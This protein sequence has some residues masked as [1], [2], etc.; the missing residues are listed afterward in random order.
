[1]KEAL[2]PDDH[3]VLGQGEL[4]SSELL[5]SSLHL[6]HHRRRRPAPDNGLNAISRR[7]PQTSDDSSTTTDASP[8]STPTTNPTSS[9][10]STPDSTQT[11]SPASTP[12]LA[13]SPSSTCAP[14]DTSNKCEKPTSGNTT[15]LPIVLGAVIPIV[16]AIVLFYFLHR[17]HVRKLRKEDANDRHKSLDFGLEVANGPSKKG[18]KG[19]G[20]AA[21][22]VT[23]LEKELRRDHGL[24]MDMGSPYIL[25]PG[26]HG[27]RES[28]HS[29]S[30]TIKET[31]DR[32][33]P[34]ATFHANDAASMRSLPA[35]QR[36]IHDGSSVY[37][38]RTD[39]SGP[40]NRADSIN[41][42]LLPNASSMPR[43]TPPQESPPS[44]LQTDHTA[45]AE[46][47]PKSVGRKPLPSNLKGVGL[48]I[49]E[50]STTENARDSYFDHNLG[51]I[52]RSNNYLGAFINARDSTL[53]PP[54]NVP[55][56]STSKLDSPALEEEEDALDTLS[57]A[58][59][60]FVGTKQTPSHVARPSV[61][62]VSIEHDSQQKHGSLAVFT[63][64]IPDP[65]EQE[66]FPT[67]TEVRESVIS[68][69]EKDNVR[70]ANLP[71]PSYEMN[72]LS[73]NFRPLPPVEPTDD[74]E[75]RAN[76]IRSFYKE[77]FDDSKP[78]AQPALPEQTQRQTYLEDY[79]AEFYGD[80]T[81]IVDART[82]DF[83]VAQAPYAQPVTRRAMTPPPRAPPQFQRPPRNVSMGNASP[84][85]HRPRNAS[86]GSSNLAPPG[87][88]A[89]SSASGRYGPGVR[90]PHPSRHLPPP[91]PLRV[92]PTPHMLREDSFALPIDF[93]PPSTYRDRAAGRP[94]SPLGGSRPYAPN[95]PSHLPLASSF[96]DL[97]AMP[98]PYALRKSGTYTGLDFAPPPRFKQSENASDSGSIRSNRSG[99]S[100][101]QLYSLRNGAYRVSRI[102]REVVGT[103]D[104]ITSSLRPKWD[105]GR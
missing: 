70:Q 35:S 81:S 25:P 54:K 58:N 93:A 43:S 86:L 5:Q 72:R 1:M 64:A 67:S 22:G 45:Q 66:Q 41:Q 79:G 68:E 42:D 4:A 39:G 74:P 26:L 38:G 85:P 18:K 33:G 2:R 7:S 82:G 16:F 101:A 14:G 34:T 91:G 90:Q 56:A 53:A 104:D 24:S 59:D 65:T 21:S 69:V 47:S 49:P 28:L 71:L 37:T 61:T 29:L 15:T 6:H 13:P 102:P 3:F 8:T 17:R 97:A 63:A 89:F 40:P 12:S 9:P 80:A 30:R 76:R 31:E 73:M 94:E 96:D 84:L 48:S 75:Q 32:Y 105:M 44:L 103:R 83:V 98:S 36:R 92:L 20:G 27:S 62:R 19:K 46:P 55:V 87:P 95:K 11:P 88:R 99:L 100:T 10:T 78:L 52:R 51:A 77:Y 57:L 23:E 50:L 60:S